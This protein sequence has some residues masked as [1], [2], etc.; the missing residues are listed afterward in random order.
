MSIYSVYVHTHACMYEFSD[1][2]HHVQNVFTAHTP[3]Q[4]SE[5]EDYNGHFM[6]I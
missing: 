1:G 2:K 4:V 6:V 5:H 3:V